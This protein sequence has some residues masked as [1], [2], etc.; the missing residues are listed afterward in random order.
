MGIFIGVD[1]GLDGG[2]I[3]IDEDGQI[4][5][6]TIMPTVGAGASKRELDLPT[7]LQFFKGMSGSFRVA[8][9]VLEK[10]IAMPKQSSVST[11]KTGRGIGLIEGIV[12]ALGFRYQVIAPRTWQKEMLRDLHKTSGNTKQASILAAERL[13]PGVD[14]RSTERSKNAHHGL[15]DAALMAEY[16]RRNFK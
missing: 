12:V 10:G 9:V 4:I 6:K 1:N 11:F 7:I 15:T 8:G 5:H 16:G 13:F 3:A 14:W 2:L